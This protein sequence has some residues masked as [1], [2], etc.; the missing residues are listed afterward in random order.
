MISDIPSSAACFIVNPS[1]WEVFCNV[2]KSKYGFK[3]K[4]IWS[5]EEVTQFLDCECDKYEEETAHLEDR[6]DEAAYYAQFG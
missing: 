6:A 5:E 4:N 1:L 2:Y 3:P